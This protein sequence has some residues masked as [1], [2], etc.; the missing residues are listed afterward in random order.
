LLKASS[1]SAALQQ[2]ASTKTSLLCQR[3][4]KHKLEAI[5]LG[6]YA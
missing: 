3:C 5:L 2:L 1:G 4:N 6:I